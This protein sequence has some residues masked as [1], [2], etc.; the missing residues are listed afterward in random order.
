MPAPTAPPGSTL[1]GSADPI[2]AVH[3]FSRRVRPDTLCRHHPG[4]GR[5]RNHLSR[6][7]AKSCLQDC[8]PGRRRLPFDQPDRAGTRPCPAALFTPDLKA[9]G[10]QRRDLIDTPKSI[11]A[12]TVHWAAAIH[13]A[14]PDLDGSVWTSR[15]CDPERCVILFGDRVSEID[16]DP[17]ECL[18]VANDAALLLELRGFGRRA[19]IDIVS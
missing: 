5:V 1:P 18:N 15:Q 17:L 14:A 6:H 8:A 3:R 4:S 11:Y 7:R 10:L 12:R 9:W 19:G 13:A 16:C 2:R